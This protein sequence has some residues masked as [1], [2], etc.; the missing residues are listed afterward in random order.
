MFLFRQMLR[1]IKIR[2]TFLYSI[3]ACFAQYGQY[4]Y[5]HLEMGLTKDII[6]KTRIRFMK[7]AKLIID[8]DLSK[9]YLPEYLDSLTGNNTKMFLKEFFNITQKNP[10][11]EIE[12]GIVRFKVVDGKI[13]NK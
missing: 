11:T 2:K 13:I 8:S 3:Y 6:E 5:R 7:I 9:E 1:G 4:Y 10:K 12:E